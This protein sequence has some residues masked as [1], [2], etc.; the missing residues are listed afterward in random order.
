LLKGDKMKELVIS[1]ESFEIKIKKWDP[2]TLFIAREVNKK[3][4]E[5][6]EEEEEKQTGSVEKPKWNLPHEPLFAEEDLLV[7]FGRIPVYRKIAEYVEEQLEEK[8]N[9][10]DVAKMIGNYYSDKLK[11]KISKQ[12][13]A[14]YASAYGRYFEEEKETIVRDKKK[15]IWEKRIKEDEKKK[16][17]RE[18]VDK[19]LDVAEKNSWGLKT[20]PIS[21]SNISKSINETEDEVINAISF[22]IKEGIVSQR[23]KNKIIFVR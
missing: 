3:I 15:G 22:L 10:S 16:K 13:L 21:I 11:K 7:R 17:K 14:S 18:T 2:F 6:M 8:T 5:D 4:K 20:Q 23:P 1:T 12:S 9:V 19:I